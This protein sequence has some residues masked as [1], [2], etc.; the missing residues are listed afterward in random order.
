MN[1]AMDFDG[2]YT[3]D[4]TTWNKVV[5]KLHKAGH[6]VYLVTHRKFSGY[7]GKDNDIYKVMPEFDGI[8]FTEGVKKSLFTKMIGL[9]ID[10]WIDNDVSKI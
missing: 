9:N 8:Y 7:N 4:P 1:I 5:K 10:V 3:L 2:T 6:N